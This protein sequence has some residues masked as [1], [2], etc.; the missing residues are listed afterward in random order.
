LKISDHDFVTLV[1]LSS[2]RVIVASLDNALNDNHFYLQ[3]WTSRILTGKKSK[4]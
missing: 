4:N 3:L 1:Q 2:R